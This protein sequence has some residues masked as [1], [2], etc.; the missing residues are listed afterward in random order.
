MTIVA[1]FLVDNN[2]NWRIYYYSLGGICFLLNILY[3]FFSVENPRYFALKQNFD[4]FKNSLIY[5]KKFNKVKNTE[6]EEEEKENFENKSKKSYLMLDDGK[7][8]YSHQSFLDNKSVVSSYNEKKFDNYIIQVYNDVLEKH[9]E[10]KEI[11]IDEENIEKNS[12]QKLVEEEDEEKKN[13]K[14]DDSEFDEIDDKQL[15]SL[16]SGF[17]VSKLAK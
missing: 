15:N 2:V 3:I 4:E 7:S 5:I 14:D 10:D 9:V 11:E 17:C 12:I 6:N 13:E 16:A 8:N 1:Y